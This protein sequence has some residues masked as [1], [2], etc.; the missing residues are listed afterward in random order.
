V[1]KLGELLV[2]SKV[3]YSNTE[4]QAEY[5]DISLVAFSR[6]V[7]RYKYLV[8]GTF[9]TSIL[10]ST[11]VALLS[12]PLYSSSILVTAVGGAPAMGS[13]L[14]RLLRGFGGGAMAGGSSMNSR[15]V[16]LSALQ[17][18]YFTRAFIDENNLLPI[19]FDD[20]WDEENKEWDVSDPEDI[21]T[22]TEGYEMFS[23]EVLEVLEQERSGLVDVKILWKDPVVAANWANS[24][25]ATTNARLRAKSIKD[26]ELA[27]TYLNEEL[28]KT[29]AV[30]LQQSLYF[31]VESE[32]QKGTMA[33][34]QKEYAFKVLSPAVPADLDKFEEPNRTFIIS[35]GFVLGLFGGVFIAILMGP[36]KKITEDIFSAH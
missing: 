11:L 30:E 15:E 14:T 28:A 16:S 10:I 32:I 29:N 2:G 6:L 23:D 20:L 12:T 33:K 34:V 36:I 19:L 31:L 3:T 1:T 7:R 35:I 17:S 24:L 5:A 8:V 9:L 13:N 26:A 18:P 22:L 4:D 25:V 27:I 21:P